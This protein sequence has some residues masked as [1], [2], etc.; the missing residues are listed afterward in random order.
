MQHSYGTR[1]ASSA[2]VPL[3]APSTPAAVGATSP[4]AGVSPRAA[5]DPPPPP[6]TGAATG[7]LAPTTPRAP[8]GAVDQATLTAVLRSVDPATLQQLLGALQQPPPPDRIVE[9]QRQ[10]GA[11]AAQ[12]V[13][14]GQQ[15]ADAEH[16][17]V[18][19]EL[20]ELRAQY[21]M[22]ALRHAGP[23]NEV[24]D[25]DALGAPANV[26]ALAGCDR[27]RWPGH[28]Y[29]GRTHAALASR[30]P[31]QPSGAAG[32]LGD[33]GSAWVDDEVDGLPL[34]APAPVPGTFGVPDPS[35][36]HAGLSTDWGRWIAENR[37]KARKFSKYEWKTLGALQQAGRLVELLGPHLAFVQDQ[38]PP[39][40]DAG[41]AVY[42]IS[43][44]VASLLEILQRSVDDYALRWNH[45]Q[46]RY[47]AFVHYA[48]LYEPQAAGPRCMHPGNLALQHQVALVDLRQAKSALSKAKDGG[49]RTADGARTRQR[50]ASDAAAPS[51]GARPAAGRG[52]IAG[53]TRRGGAAG[54]APAAA[55]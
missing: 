7:A 45:S 29:C 49:G 3:V 41:A 18:V 53:G 19:R 31:A 4:S 13:P 21:D 27:R 38:L 17:R 43:G 55:Q 28:A 2:E 54:A 52:G 36:E 16:E 46:Q 50:Q 24:V 32:I 15:R 35:A 40:N 34:S 1:A 23:T 25:V 42:E 26:C 20:V 44:A 11:D 22:L 14:D 37:E 5:I 9:T 30:G 10:P 51:A 39:D 12:A 6:A 48:S 47:E 8:D 33:G